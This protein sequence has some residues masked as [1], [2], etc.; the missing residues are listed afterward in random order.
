MKLKSIATVLI[1]LSVQFSFAQKIKYK[2]LFPILDTKNWADGGSQLKAFLSD[3][4]YAKDKGYPNANLQMALWLEDRFRAMD[5]AS[6][7]VAGYTVGDSAIYFFGNAKTLVDE[8][9]LKKNDQYYQSFFRRDL[10]TGDFGIKESDVHLDIEKK[11]EDIEKRMSTSKD[12]N[13]KVKS[14][15]DGKKKT[16]DSYQKLASR[17]KSY[18]ELLLGADDDANAL[19][20]Q[21]KADASEIKALAEEVKSVAGTLKTTKFQDEIVFKPIDEFG[22][23]GMTSTDLSGGTIEMWDYEDWAIT[24]TSEING[25]VGILKSMVLKHS[26]TIREKKS[27]IKKSRDAEVDTLS[28]ELA[29]LFEKYDPESIAKKLLLTE[30]SEARILKQ[31]DYSLNKALLDSTLVGEQLDIYTS[32]KADSEEMLLVLGSINTTELT[33]AKKTYGDYLD[34]FFQ[35]HGTAGNYV[36]QMKTWA[37]QQKNWASDAV[38]YWTERNRWGI[39]TTEGQEEKKIPL[40]IQDAPESEF[41]TVGMPISTNQEVVVF[42]TN[43]SEKKGFVFSFDEGRFTKWMLEF[44]LPGDGSFKFATDTVVAPKGSTSFFLLNE[45]VQENNLAVVSYS[46]AGALNWSAVVTVAKTP[47]DYK[48]DDITQELTILLYPEE[49]LPLDNGEVGYLVID[50]EGNAR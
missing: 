8:K 42:G 41:F 33:D 12:L 24:T 18:N 37:N 20:Q 40:F 3:P 1:L 16:G 43:I 5:I 11:I 39:M 32:V 13:K 35:S 45:A 17:F 25:S 9:E 14:V 29:D 21:L 7:T 49:D 44:E 15:E 30:A 31:I 6:D 19:L 36:S 10:R 48:F 47:V 23:D 34:S 27:L 4:A 38:E 2:D 22:K 28:Q 46:N 50:K 26:K